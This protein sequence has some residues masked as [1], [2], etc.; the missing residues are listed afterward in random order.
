VTDEDRDLTTVEAEGGSRSSASAAHS[1]GHR[2]LPVWQETILLLAGALV[3]AI[4]I[5][6]LF[7]Q[8]FYIPSESMEPGLVKNDRILVEKPSYWFGGEP[9]RGDVVVFKDPGG[10]LGPEDVSEGANPV[11]RVLTKV[12]LYPSGGHLVK[13]V[14][15]VP[16]DVVECCDEQGRLIIN[17]KPID[18][19]SYARPND[20]GCAPGT[21][22]VCYGPMPGVK[23]W[24][25]QTVPKGML[26][27]MGDNRA[28]SA[29]S[30]YHL[31]TP[32][33]TECSDSPWV[34]ADLVVGKV[35]AVV[36]P[37]SKM[38]LEHRPDSF[39]GVGSR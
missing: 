26:F 30:S 1:G 32:D 39:A 35:G 3:L 28:H 14:V 36:W 38:R 7:V 24:K 17:G 20:Q 31:C 4:L 13:R 22:G 9:Q 37:A 23:H 11:T 21:Q 33:E 6:A 10:W 27:V 18:E 12:G 15:G 2:S 5:K 29:D 25:T 19:S 34:S 16:G 8:A